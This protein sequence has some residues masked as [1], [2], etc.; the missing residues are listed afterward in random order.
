MH[1]CHEDIQLS[2][3]CR[4]YKELKDNHEI[5]PYLQRNVNRALRITLTKLRLN[6]HKLLI[7]SGRWLKAKIEYGDRL[8]TLCSKIDIQDEYHVLMVC[9]HY[10]ILR[11][12][13]V[14]GLVCTNSYNL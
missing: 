12:K 13:Y 8:C 6:R 10:T 14:R 7:E 3:R 4:L 9:P 2:S 11:K 1:S 5:K